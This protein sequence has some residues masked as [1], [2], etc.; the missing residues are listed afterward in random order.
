[1]E[2]IGV[3]IC[4]YRILPFSMPTQILFKE[5]EL[6]GSFILSSDIFSDERG[7]FLQDV[8][9]RRIYEIKK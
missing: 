8:L 1:M 4:Q 7:F 5:I 9:Q 3:S 2:F 6:R